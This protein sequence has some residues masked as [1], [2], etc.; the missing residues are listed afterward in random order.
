[1]RKNTHVRKATHKLSEAGLT[2]RE[3][4]IMDLVYAR[5]EVSARD[6]WQ[7]IPERP[8]YSTV[9][10]LLGVLEGKGH[11]TRRQ[12]GKALL[13]RATKPR[14]QVAASALRR[15]LATFFEG[16]VERAVSGLL[17]LE[18]RYLTDEELT[19]IAR[20]IKEARRQKNP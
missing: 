12:F 2:R 8:S 9:R 3:R 11:L 20:L 18:D 1:M 16:S 14:S 13:Y 19:R 6:V 4:Q 17:E 10:T 7:H 5:D 15:L